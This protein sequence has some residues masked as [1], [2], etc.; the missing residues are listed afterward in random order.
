MTD[1]PPHIF[2]TVTN[3]LTYDQRMQRICTALGHAGY[4]VTLVGRKLPNS[5]KLAEM[6]FSNKRIKCWF[7]KGKLFYLEYSIRLFLWLMMQ[8]VQ[9]ICAID[10]DTILPC[11]MA[12]MFKRIPRVY[13]AHELFTEQYEVQRRPLI[14][15][16][17]LAVEKLAV[18]RFQ[19]GYTVNTF[20]Q[21][22]LARR[23]G[24]QYAIVRN[25]P[26]ASSESS[27]SKPDDALR[28]KLPSGR[29]FLYQGAV[30]E[31]R[32]FETLIPAMKQVDVPLVIAGTGNLIQKIRLLVEQNG[33]Q[34]QVIFLGMLTPVQ[35][36]I[37]T[38]NAYAGITIF[39][40]KGM[41]Q[42]YSLANRF[43]DY[44]QAGIPQICVAYPEYTAITQNYPVALHVADVEPET[45]AAAMNKLLADDVLYH[46]L[47]VAT[48]PAA[49]HLSWEKE[50][51]VLLA[52]WRQWIPLNH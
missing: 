16:I 44:I 40:E 7:T 3:D 39:S 52:C 43:F 33:L 10:L 50:K 36:R 42:Y 2:F 38:P 23:Y 13:D 4:R 35:L 47:R 12:S 26:W 19:H 8:N 29:F 14:Q 11:L 27:T 30:N 22:E 6:R 51:D 18:P 46:Q 9:A 31:G 5:V 24:V 41:N 25:L 32:S 28:Q 17:W 15:K 21:Q 49:K 45:L 48:A 20:L 1:R 34:E 37:L